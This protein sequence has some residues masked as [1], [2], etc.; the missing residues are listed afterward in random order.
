MKVRV[1]L[2]F[3]C[4]PP[5]GWSG[6]VGSPCVGVWR[7]SV[8]SWTCSSAPWRS[9]GRPPLMW[10]GDR[11]D[12]LHTHTFQHSLLTSCPSCWLWVIYDSLC[13]L[14]HISSVVTVFLY[15]FSRS[16]NQTELQR[17]SLGRLV[18]GVDIKIKWCSVT[19]LHPHSF[20]FQINSRNV[21]PECSTPPWGTA[22]Y[23]PWQRDQRRSSFG[24]CHSWNASDFGIC[25][26]KVECKEEDKEK[27]VKASIKQG[28]LRLRG[29]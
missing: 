7:S 19:V 20:H 22:S 8:W 1:C 2:T 15:T 29:S 10:S 25:G 16:K 5:P 24:K 27:K 14:C 23:D 21:I 28:H 12:T 4:C 9:L 18:E 6:Q 26:R 17:T 11:Q 3:P 13:T